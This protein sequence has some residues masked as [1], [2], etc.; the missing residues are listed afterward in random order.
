MTIKTWAA[1]VASVTLLCTT[2]L[3]MHADDA[4]TKSVNAGPLKLEIPEDWKAAEASNQFRLLQCAVPPVEGDK[5]AAEFVVF[6]FGK[7]GGG[8]VEQNIQR[9]K[10][11]FETD[12]LKIKILDG[13]SKLGKYTLVD[14]TGTW[15]KPVGPP[16][17]MKTEK[18]PGSRALQLVL[19]TEKEGNFFLRLAGSQKTVDANIEGL[20]AAIGAD[21]KS[22]KAR[23]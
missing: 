8:G 18:A 1:C 15:N 10:G 2:L 20:R 23:D 6:H 19:Q 13:E 5:S 12:G 17:A 22:E 4:K 16:I 9:W 14:L 7:G 21:A 11:Q 3:P